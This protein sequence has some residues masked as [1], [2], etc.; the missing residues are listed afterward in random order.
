MKKKVG[1]TLDN[2]IYRRVKIYCAKK[3]IS[4]SELFAYAVEMYINRV[5][6]LEGEIERQVFEDEIERKY[7]DDIVKNNGYVEVIKYRKE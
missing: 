6:I 4:I 1:I 7:Y 3:E 5:E 2:E